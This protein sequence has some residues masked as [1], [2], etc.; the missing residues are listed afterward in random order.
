MEH[1]YCIIMAGGKGERFWPLSTRLVP[2]PFVRLV[3]DKSM[4][5]MTVD[6]ALRLV[7]ADHIFVVLGEEH[8]AVAREQLPGLKADQIIVEP[9][10]RDTAPC[11]GFAAVQLRL[12]DP[13]AVMVVLPADHYVPDAGSFADTI[14][15][16]VRCARK[17]DHLV[18]TG[19][20]PTRPETG[21]GYI[22]TAGK[23]SDI[24]ESCYRI[25]G[26]VE[27]PDEA[28][29]S[30]YLSEGGYYWNSGIFVWKAETVLQG[31]ERHMPVLRTGLGRMEEALRTGDEK[32]V[33]ALFK[34]FERI[35]IDYGLMEKADNVLMVKATFVWDDVGTWSSL[36]RTMTLDGSGNYIS[37]RP[38]CIDVRDS[39]IYADGVNL[40]LIGVSNLVVVAS[41]EGI[42][43]CDQR[44]DQETRQIARMIEEQEKKEKGR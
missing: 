42:L 36:R 27:K 17:G 12:R 26:F 16:A 31:M 13:D 40:G 14:T 37:G 10:G 24:D 21:Y 3:G 35:S 44:R 15:L 22:H 9:A 20:Q 4:I 19:I 5:Q 30:R 28:K 11:I 1:T 6:R 43:V 34:G 29:A 41:K 18:T 25:S 7:P 23:A 8:A 2:K 33:A 32:E 38:V 39:V